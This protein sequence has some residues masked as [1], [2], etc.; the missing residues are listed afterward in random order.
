MRDED[1]VLIGA[2]L[3]AFGVKGE[4]R[5]RAFTE[6][7][8]S[9][10]AYGPLYDQGGRVVATPK[11]VRP[12]KDGVALSVHEPLNREAAEALR[13]TGLHVPRSALP[14]ADPDEFYHV[15]LI[16]CSVEAL[17]GT[18]LGLVKAVRNFGA[19]DLLEIQ[20][21][22][23]KSPSWYLPFTKAAA[24]FVDLARRRIVASPLSQSDEHEPP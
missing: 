23:E 18:P 7:P 5:I 2:V 20:P 12:I 24:P 11:R 3:G 17:D 19:G 4:L 10:A 15:D 13:G 8:A 22:Q 14:E 6:D 9:V 21:P 16:G 1:L